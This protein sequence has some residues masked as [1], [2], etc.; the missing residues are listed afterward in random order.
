[1]FLAAASGM[2]LDFSDLVST[3]VCEIQLLGF[4]SLGSNSS[5][6][7]QLH[8]EHKESSRD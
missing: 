6:K 8:L 4:L 7:P 1:M 3:L 5:F 2:V